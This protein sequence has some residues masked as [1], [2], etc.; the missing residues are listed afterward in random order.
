MPFRAGRRSHPRTISPQFDRRRPRG[1]HARW[2]HGGSNHHRSRRRYRRH[3]KPRTSTDFHPGRRAHSRQCRTHLAEASRSGKHAVPDVHDLLSRYAD[4][5]MAQIPQSVGCAAV[6]PLEARCARWLLLMHDRL[7]QPDLPSRR[8]CSP[9]C[10]VRH[11]PMS[12]GSQAV[13]RSAAQSFHGAVLSI[14]YRE[15]CSK[16]RRANVTGWFAGISS[17]FNQVC[18]PRGNLSGREAFR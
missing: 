3:R 16:K 5:L 9:T 6:H 4:C 10:S 18:I 2:T 14:S 13:C 17:A 8:K 7:R 12:H 11:A 1:A 15:N